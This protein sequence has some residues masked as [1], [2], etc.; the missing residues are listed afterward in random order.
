MNPA[1]KIFYDWK[2]I[3]LLVERWKQSGYEIGFTNGCF[4]ILHF[5]H[6]QYLYQ[7]SLLVDKLI[8]GLNSDT[9]IGRIKGDDRPI[10][11][12]K[13]R[14]GIMASLSFVD[15][16]VVFEENTPATLIEEIIPD[17][18]IKGL[19]YQGKEVVGREFVEANGGKVVLLPF[20][21]GYSTTKIIQKIRK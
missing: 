1:D 14:S 17:F 20:E 4:D 5:G 9:S 19:D 10:M 7:A 13:S 16:V 6:I 18:L 11:D 3:C 15:A 2:D 21:K 8:L 12:E